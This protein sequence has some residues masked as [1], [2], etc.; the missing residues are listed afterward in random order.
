M[1]LALY[2]ILATVAGPLVDSYL[3]RRLARGKEDP[4][5]IG[6]RR[7]IAGRARPD[8]L[9]IWMHA[10]SVGESVALLPLIERLG[11]ERPDL[12]VLVTTG[13]VTSAATMAQRLPG[14][15]VHQFV[16][17]DR[18]AWVARFLDH[19]RPDLS[20]WIESDLWPNL[21]LETRARG[22]PMVLLDARMSA[23][24]YRGWRRAFGLARPIFA[25][26][27][28]ILASSREQVERFRNLGGRDVRVSPSLKAAG[29]PPPIDEAELK[30]LSAA[31]GRRPVWLASNTHPGE[32]EIVFAVQRRLMS[33]F[34]DM[35][36]ILAPRHPDRASTITV[37]AT[38]AGLK[39]ALRSSGSVVS[40]DIHVYLVD[41]LGQLG[42]LHALIAGRSR[43]VFLGGSLV[44]VGGHNPLEAAHA[45]VALIF[46]PMM[47]NN[48]SSADELLAAD[49]ALEVTDGDALLAVVR[50]LMTDP[51][52]ASGMGER[53]VAV[54]AAKR[55]GLDCIMAEIGPLLPTK[56]PGP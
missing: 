46:G 34:D 30:E 14:G 27:D 36:C 38:D 6:E 47:P 1:M 17:V 3:E 4:E 9:L 31:I 41:S 21:V 22:I 56:R 12:S 5:R 52:K 7:G 11:A 32:D 26:F 55:A 35:L 43:V 45:G 42:T 37:M 44:P 39:S 50:N 49:A 16:P 10:A 13:T 40:E 29:A 53:G 33:E 51:E 54:A 19:W 28:L 20:L 23:E 8:G 2:R 18:P 25:A 15:V 48:R 24:S